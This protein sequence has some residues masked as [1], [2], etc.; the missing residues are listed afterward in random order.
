MCARSTGFL[1]HVVCQVEDDGHH[2]INRQEV[3]SVEGVNDTLHALSK[4][5]GAR[6]ATQHEE[7][8]VVAVYGRGS[9]NHLTFLVVVIERLLHEV[10]I[11]SR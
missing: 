8:E 2:L 7:A 3:V 9:I 4:R 1:V 10:D 11:V 6:N 5:A